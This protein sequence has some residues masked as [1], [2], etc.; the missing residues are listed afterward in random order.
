MKT[1]FGNTISDRIQF[2][3]VGG[4]VSNPKIKT[5][6]YNEDNPNFTTGTFIEFDNDVEGRTLNLSNENKKYQSYSFMPPVKT[7]NLELNNFNQVYSTGSGDT[8]STILKKNLIIRCQS[9]YELTNGTAYYFKRGTFVI[10]EPEFQ[11]VKV[12][13]QGRDY[14]K[15]ALET[16]IN[17]PDLTSSVNVATAITYVLDRCNIPYDTSNWN[18]TNTVVSMDATLA[19]QIENKSGWKILDFLM[20]SINAGDDDWRL[21]TE[22]DGGLSLKILP[23]DKEADWSAHYFYNIES[24]QKGFDSDRQ[25]QR[26]TTM[27]KS[28]L[29]KQE[30]LLK[31]YNATASSPSLHLT[32]GSAALYV[33][34]TNSTGTIN[35]ETARANTSIDFS[36]NSGDAYNVRVYGCKPKNAIAN[37]IWSELG[38]SDNILKNNGSTYKRVNPFMSQSMADAFCSYMIGINADPRKKITLTMVSNPYLELNDKVVVFDLYTYTDDI[39]NLV[40]ITENWNNPALKDTLVLKDANINIDNFIWDR[41][42]IHPGLNDLKYDTGLVWDQNMTIGGSDTNT[43]PTP[44]RMA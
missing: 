29:V 20:D 26:I 18:L 30:E 36:V 11:D 31:Q 14:L 17:M 4:A 3:E 42:G 41:N 16:E 25:L 9:G 21:K 28:I 7:M 27:N 37:E 10:D 24:V 15:K 13:V 34:Y 22:E 8:K 6:W 5:E 32:Y 38:N 2:D 12:S 44:I 1:A 23:T 35:S 19:E 33:R 40:S 39:Y 43:Y